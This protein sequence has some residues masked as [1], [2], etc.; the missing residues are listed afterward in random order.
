MEQR[1]GLGLRPLLIGFLLS[2]ACYVLVAA[3][4]FVGQALADEPSPYVAPSELALEPELSELAACPSAEV[5]I[6]V[7]EEAEA[8]P[9]DL[10]ELGHLRIEQQQACRAQSDRLDRVVERLWWIVAEQLRLH[11]QGVVTNEKLEAV[12]GSL[13]V[14]LSTEVKGFT[15]LEPLPVHETQQLAV[16]EPIAESVDASGE[17]LKGGVYFVAGVIVAAFVCYVLYRQVMP[18]A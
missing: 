8:V 5:P 15:S 14:P 17:A 9:P 13:E 7:E 16:T 11:A 2:L 18:R 3:G 10:R 12:L 1:P 4:V 6:V